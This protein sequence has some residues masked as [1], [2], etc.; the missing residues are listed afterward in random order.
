MIFRGVNMNEIKEDLNIL[1]LEGFEFLNYTLKI[2]KRNF[3]NFF[4]VC[5]RGIE[6]LIFI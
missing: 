2:L 5:F 1:E 3:L 4:G 6:S